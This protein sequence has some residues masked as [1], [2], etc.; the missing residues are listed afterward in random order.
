M[1]LE[2]TPLIE[3]Q[4]YEALE[5]L[6]TGII[7]GGFYQS[8]C[9][10]A[11]SRMEDAVLTVSYADAE[12]IQGGR[13][14][15]NIYVSDINNGTGRDVPNKIR[16]QELSRIGDAV[17]ETLNQAYTDYL[18]YLT[19]A[20]QSMPDLGTNQHFITINI[21]FKISPFKP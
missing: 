21:G 16:L 20:T 10:P 7:T 19:Q 11:D 2:G 12:Q 14:K 4:M 9:R 3:Q 13:A 15:L 6:L 5:G 8:D 17:I 1:A 18:F